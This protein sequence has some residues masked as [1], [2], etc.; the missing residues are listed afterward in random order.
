[1]DQVQVLRL[2]L[3][4]FMFPGTSDDDFPGQEWTEV[5]AGNVPADRRFLQ[6]AGTIYTIARSC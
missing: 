1:M 3:C 5:T 6:S 2:N 4:N